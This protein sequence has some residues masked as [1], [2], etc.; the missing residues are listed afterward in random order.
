MAVTVNAAPR[1]LGIEQRLQPLEQMLGGAGVG[2]LKLQGNEVRFQEKLTAFAAHPLAAQRGARF[3]RA[4]P[5]DGMKPRQRA[6]QNFQIFLDLYVGRVPAL[7]REH[8]KTE[9]GVLEQGGAVSVQGSYR[10]QLMLDEFCRERMLFEDL[11]IAPALGTVELGDHESPVL[12]LQLVHP[13][14]VAVQLQQASSGGEPGG[15]QRVEYQIRR[16]AGIRC[17]G[18][19]F[20]HESESSREVRRRGWPTTRGPR[21]RR[22]TSA[23]ARARRP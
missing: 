21:S 22:P 12:D 9:S 11:R 17:A 13:V 2:R 23:C 16:Q 6:G 18:G 14:F 3:E 7:P 15:L 5:A 19:R 4:Y 8:G 10:R 20:A 1:M